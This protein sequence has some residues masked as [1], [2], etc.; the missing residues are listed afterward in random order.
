[1][2]IIGSCVMS[3]LARFIHLQMAANE[4][5]PRWFTAVGRTHCRPSR[6]TQI[7]TV[8]VHYWL[9]SV[10]ARTC[11]ATLVDV[12][13]NP[14]ELGP[15]VDRGSEAAADRDEVR[16]RVLSVQTIWWAAVAIVVVG[17]AVGVWLL[18]AY[19]DGDDQSRNQL[20]AIKTAG[21]LVIGAG[22]AAALLLAA[23][24]QRSA[25]IALK[26][27]DRD[28]AHQERVATATEKDAVERRIT[29]LYTK[30]ADQ[31]GSE[32]AAVRLAGLYAFERLA[33]NNPDQRQTIVN[34]VCAYLR[35][36]FQPPGEPLADDADDAVPAAYLQ[37]VEEREVRLTAQRLLTVHLRRGDGDHP[38]DTYWETIDL[39]LTGALLINFS[40]Q[41]C[42]VRSADFDLA[43]F[44]GDADFNG[45]T[46]SSATF[47]SATFAADAFFN[48][49][50]FMD[51]AG[52]Q[53]AS[54]TSKASFPLITCRGTANFELATF[55]GDA[56]FKKATFG[57]ATFE[58][59]CFSGY[60]DF[61]WATFD[62]GYFKSTNFGLATFE[63]TAFRT[64]AY[65]E[66]AKFADQVNFES[67]RFLGR[68][69]FKSTT[70]TGSVPDEV[71]R[72]FS[73]TDEG[74]ASSP[75]TG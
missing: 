6:S 43:T 45:T 41:S 42:T 71:R 5:D 12:T 38:V 66:S 51:F 47:R 34:V 59:A 15:L 37:R 13:T 28:Q 70:F 20:E 69:Y 53:S 2:R 52:F 32:K 36:P 73:P 9:D 49:A 55:T 11:S 24:R 22:G 63:L 4:G 30:A 50:T 44:T 3:T 40:L 19:G 74:I 31:L 33:Q 26:Q 27:K 23:R 39:D 54:F 48:R 10:A 64:Q 60:T 18:M 21:T 57:F 35:M 75:E 61:E 56:D 62:N 72:V 58:S 17:V 1:M 8:W 16:Y 68:S 29:E 7:V 25:E 46:F 14:S 67:A 65:F